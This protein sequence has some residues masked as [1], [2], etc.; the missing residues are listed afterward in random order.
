MVEFLPVCSLKIR[1]S[2]PIIGNFLLRNMKISLPLR[3]KYIKFASKIQLESNNY[4]EDY[5]IIGVYDDV[6][7]VIH[8]RQLR[9]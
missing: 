6:F 2:Y 3:Y 5:Y 7:C 4:E 9:R 1:I 8:I